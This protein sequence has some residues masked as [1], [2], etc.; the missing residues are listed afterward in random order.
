MGRVALRNLS[1]S[2]IGRGYDDWMI[3][4]DDE[5]VRLTPEELNHLRREAARKGDVVGDVTTSEELRDAIAAALPDEALA[6]FEAFLLK[7][8]DAE[9]PGPPPSPASARGARTRRPAR[10]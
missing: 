10:R 9:P 7:R 3:F 2:G 1:C 4:V 6:S 5:Q 8:G